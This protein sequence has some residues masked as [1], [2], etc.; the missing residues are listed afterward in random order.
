MQG[1]LK[2]VWEQLDCVYWFVLAV[3]G[4]FIPCAAFSALVVSLLYHYFKK[5]LTELGYQSKV[6]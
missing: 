6:V 5:N 2:E 3:E 4:N 1:V